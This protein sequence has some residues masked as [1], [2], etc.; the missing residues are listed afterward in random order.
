MENTAN[1][2]YN[3]TRFTP[4]FPSTATWKSFSSND[5]NRALR[6]NTAIN[7]EQSLQRLSVLQEQSDKKIELAHSIL[8]ELANQF[9]DE[10]LRDVVTQIQH[11]AESWLDDFEKSIFDGLTLQELLHERRHP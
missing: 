2:Q 4:Y 8:G 10:E 3:P 7:I 5:L 6:T 11:L 1:S 9:T